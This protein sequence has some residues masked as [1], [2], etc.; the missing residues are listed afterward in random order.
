[1]PAMDFIAFQGLLYHW[2]EE[3]QLREHGWSVQAFDLSVNF[4]ELQL[5]NEGDILY[6]RESLD[7]GPLDSAAV[8]EWLN[9]CLRQAAGARLSP[10][11]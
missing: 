10:R 1:M 7:I 8:E 5:R 6:L 4:V 9:R 2:A 3:K 11:P